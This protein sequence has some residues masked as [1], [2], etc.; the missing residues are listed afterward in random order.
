MA[1]LTFNELMHK[2]NCL[3]SKYAILVVNRLRN[4]RSSH[5]GLFW[6]KGVLKICS[7]LTGENPCRSVISV[8]LLCNFIHTL[9]W[10]FSCKFAAYFQNNFLRTPEYMNIFNIFNYRCLITQ[11]FCYHLETFVSLI[12][13]AKEKEHFTIKARW[14]MKIW[15]DI[16]INFNKVV[17]F[18]FIFIEFLGI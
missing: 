2:E 17:L 9:A 5:P 1:T 12:C 11:R 14:Q 6:R 7:K 13:Y 8:T 15:M 18:M 3:L 16:N 10:L 4:I